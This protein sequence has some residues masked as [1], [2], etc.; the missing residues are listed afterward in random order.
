VGEV[1]GEEALTLFQAMNTGHTTYSTLHADSIET[2]INRLENPPINVPRSMLEALDI[3]SVQVMSRRGDERV[4]RTRHLSEIAGVDSRTGDINSNQLFKWDA[5]SDEMD[6][7]GNSIILDDI[8]EERGVSRGE[9]MRELDNR[10]R[11]LQYMVDEE[12]DDYKD[13]TS[14][15]NRYYAHPESVL[16]SASEGRNSEGNGSDETDSETG[17]GTGTGA[18][19]KDD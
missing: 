14:M 15:V 2:V 17:A 19:S 11:V 8:R 6:K 5:A 4:R 12:I 13:F 9:V 7:T 18:I 16:E 3:I 10:R 1:R